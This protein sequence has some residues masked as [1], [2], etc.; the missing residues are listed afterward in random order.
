M[1]WGDRFKFGMF[2]DTTVKGV[3]F[4]RPSYLVWIYTY[5]SHTFTERVMC[6]VQRYVDGGT[7]RTGLTKR[8]LRDFY[9]RQAERIG[10][11]W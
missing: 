6:N 9:D 3:W 11:P 2:Q 5:T 7:N 1:D 8:L 4:R 10:G